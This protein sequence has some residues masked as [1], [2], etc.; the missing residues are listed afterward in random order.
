MN[1]GSTIPKVSFSVRIVSSYVT[2]ALMLWM[3]FDVGEIGARPRL[4]S[5]AVLPDGLRSAD[6]GVKSANGFALGIVVVLIL[7][8]EAAEREHG[9]G[10]DQT[11][12]GGRDVE[13]PDLGALVLR[14]TGRPFG[15][16]A[17]V[18]HHQP[19]PGGGV[20]RIVR[21]GRLEPG[22]R[23]AEIEV[24]GVGRGGLEIDAVEEVLLVAV[25]VHDGEFRTVEK[26]AGI[27]AIQRK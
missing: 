2:P 27:H 12:P 21:V 8:R 26:A 15:P 6:P 22:A 3:P 11:R 25:V 17:A 20:L 1:V 19:V 16:K 18:V 4:V 24:D 23:E 7:P 14:A 9:V 10:A 5:R 13:G